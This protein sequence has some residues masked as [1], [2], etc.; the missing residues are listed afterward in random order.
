[1]ATA[2]TETGV[3]PEIMA[4]AQLVAE[5][6][7]TGKPIP[8]KVAQR[9]EAEAD[10]ITARLRQQFGTVDIGVPAIRELRGD[11]PNP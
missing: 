11:L 1:M 7:A 9:V 6:V 5:C 3:L 4:D 10:Q 2:T 8:P